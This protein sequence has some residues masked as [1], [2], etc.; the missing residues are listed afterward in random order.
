[1]KTINRYR[2]AGPWVCVIAVG[3]SGCL[4]STDSEQSGLQTDLN[5]ARQRWESQDIQDYNLRQR[6]L[7]FCGPEVNRLTEIDVRDGIAVGWRDVESG[8]PVDPQFQ[9]SFRSV[10]RLF[11]LIQDAIDRDAVSIIVEYQTRLGYP[12]DISID[13]DAAV[14]DEEVRYETTQIT[15]FQ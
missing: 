8:V 2:M 6:N 3:L 5:E 13:Y 4:F 9:N 10:T 11:D 14:A 7:C 15:T 1:M 12:F